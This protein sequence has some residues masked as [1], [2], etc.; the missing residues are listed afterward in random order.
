MVTGY[1]GQTDRSDMAVQIHHDLDWVYPYLIA[2]L[3][4][5]YDLAA[6]FAK[7]ADKE[8]AQKAIVDEQ[9]I[10]NG[11]ENLQGVLQGFHKKPELLARV[12]EL[13]KKTRAWA[14]QPGHE[15]HA[16]GIARLDALIAAEHAQARS[17]FER[18]VSFGGSRLLT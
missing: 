11:L 10:Q 18:G 9:G 1:P 14:A 4:E 17:D 6:S 16:D 5:R 15:K 13:D 7:D 12:D 3:Q 8:R 2:Y